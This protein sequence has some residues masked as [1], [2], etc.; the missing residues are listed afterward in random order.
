[1]GDTCLPL[2]R[3]ILLVEDNRVNQLVGRALLEHLGFSVDLAIDGADALRAAARKP[4]RA[5]LMDC[6]IPGV[7]G[8]QATAAIRLR[9]GTGRRTPIIAVTATVNH[10]NRQRCLAAGMDEYLGKPLDLAGVSAA[11]ARCG[12]TGTISLDNAAEVAQ[13]ATEPARA[14]DFVSQ[15]RECPVLDPEVVGRLGRLGDATGESLMAQLAPLF[16]VHAESYL[17]DLR[18]ALAVHDAHAVT[19]AA[20]ALRGASANLGATDLARRCAWME[21]HGNAGDLTRADPL[22]DAITTELGR[23]RGALEPWTRSPIEAS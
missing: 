14:I 4:Y 12:V 20:H 6:Q 23:V 9:E 11:L 16:L 10:A 17:D 21:T 7:D 18:V 22:L 13:Q 19:M 3:A 5:I 15:V 1:M 8:Y 2:T